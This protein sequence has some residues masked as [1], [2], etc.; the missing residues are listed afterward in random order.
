MLAVLGM[1]HHGNTGPPRGGPGVEQGPDLVG[2][3]NVGAKLFE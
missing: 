1:D 3:D 2:V